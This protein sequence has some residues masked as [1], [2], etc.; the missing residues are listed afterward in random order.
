MSPELKQVSIFDVPANV[1]DAIAHETLNRDDSALGVRILN[2]SA[3]LVREAVVSYSG[4]DTIGMF[5][6]RELAV[7][8]A[9]QITTVTAAELTKRGFQLL[10]KGSPFAAP[11]L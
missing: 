6:L 8:Y 2:P 9:T 1:L 5:G 10:V 3:N 4:G 11:T 7:T